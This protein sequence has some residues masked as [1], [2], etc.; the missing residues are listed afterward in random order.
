MRGSWSLKAVLPTVAPD[1]DYLD[2]VVDELVAHP[3]DVLPWH[4]G[5]LLTNDRRH[6]CR[7]FPDALDQGVQLKHPPG[8]FANVHQDRPW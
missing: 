8:C 1:L 6:V 7:G 2:V 5:V 3:D 4:L